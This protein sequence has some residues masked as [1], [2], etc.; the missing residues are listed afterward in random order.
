[1]PD[2]S[3]HYWFVAPIAGPLILS[4]A[5]FLVQGRWAA[6]L[7]MAAA[8][9]V[10]VATGAMTAAVCRSGPQSYAL[11]S[12]LAPLGIAL[13]ADGLTCAMLWMSA[14][15][16]SVDSLYARDYFAVPAAGNPVSS[17]AARP[18][19]LGVASP[20]AAL[21]PQS[22]F[23]PLWLLLWCGLHALFLSR[24]VFNLYVTLE[25]LTLTA[26]ALV[27]VAGTRAA[28]EAALRYWLAAL[29]G[30]LLYLAGV[31]VLYGA[32][33]VLDIPSLAAGQPADGPWRAALVL[34]LLGLMLKT[35][36]FPFHFWLPP[37][38]GSAPAPVSALLSGLVVKGSFYILLRLWFELFPRPMVDLVGLLPAVLG[39]AAILWGSVQAL[40]AERLKMLIAYSTVAQLG[41]LFLVLG[42]A[43]MSAGGGQAVWSAGILFVLSHALGKSALFL[44]A[45]TI[46]LVVG[47]DRVRD[48]AGAGHRLPVTFLAI[49]LASVSLMGLP[50]TGAFMAKWVLLREALAAGQVGLAVVI[51]AGGWLAAGYLFRVLGAAFAA[52]LPGGSEEASWGLLFPTLVT[53]ALAVASGVLAGAPFMPLGWAQLIV[54][55]AYGSRVIDRGL[56]N[57]WAFLSVDN[58]ML[59]LALVCPLLG[60]GLVLL[61]PRRGWVL[62][63]AALAALPAT[64][65][66]FTSQ[67]T[68]NI[69]LTWL[70]LHMHLG[71][72]AVGLTF[73]RF[74]ALL[75]L[76][77]GIYAR[78]YLAGDP[79]AGRFFVYFQL[80]MAGNLGLVLAQDMA[81]YYLFFALMSFAS[82]PLVIYT[83]PAEDGRLSLRESTVFRGAKDDDDVTKPTGGSILRRSG[84]APRRTRL[85]GAGGA[86][87]DGSVCRYLAGDGGPGEPFVPGRH[88]GP[89]GGARGTR[90]GRP[91][92]AG[93]RHQGRPG[94]AAHVAAAGS[95]GSPH[96]GQRG[97]EWSDDQGRL[98]GLAADAAPGP[99]GA[100]GL[101]RAVPDAGPAHGAVRRRR[102]RDAAERE[103][104]AGLFQHQPDGMDHAGTGRRTDCAGCLAGDP[105]RPA[106]LCVAPRSE[107][108]LSVS[109]RRRTR[110]FGRCRLATQVPEGRYVGALPG[111][112]GSTAD[113]RG[114]EQVGPQGFTRR[115][116]GSL[117]HAV[118]LAAAAGIGRHHAADGPVSLPGLAACG[119]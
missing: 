50:P 17:A 104:S 3:A 25:L 68:A 8:L 93:V 53:A 75:W 52:R 95:S 84:C 80:A 28:T 56:G 35:A 66:A 106:R 117:V 74:T 15:V 107:Q 34:V 12:W 100:T 48:L 85:H 51:V 9:I 115:D 26:V 78:G 103:R 71:V 21:E 108:R 44:A 2:A 57:E 87:R 4:L 22:A 83:A 110:W 46:Q 91:A 111:P 118:G 20:A 23:W 1:M 73:L 70:L 40:A 42:L 27:A 102:W 82:Y 60:A 16:G 114:G 45:G 89:G 31:V 61:L 33:G 79:R 30:S 101:G 67:T 112:G 98:A 37:A 99:G 90:P 29:A 76:L 6:R 94:S 65:L 105:A 5:A 92:A 49:G 58:G 88:D 41:Y 10:I 72:D 19:G 96:A 24:D 64:W 14:V 54:E 81:T 7:G 77:G 62:E 86:G 113:D 32:C 36:I 11:G 47:H 43:G 39:A 109:Q 55:R 63:L 97:P 59:V 13:Y 116:A 18:G 38:H 119:G 69:D